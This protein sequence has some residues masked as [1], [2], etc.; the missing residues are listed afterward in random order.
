MQETY[1]LKYDSTIFSYTLY[2]SDGTTAVTAAEWDVLFGSAGTANFRFSTVSPSAAYYTIQRPTGATAPSK[3]LSSS[4]NTSA[5]VGTM[6]RGT[7]NASN[8]Q[9]T[10]FV[11]YHGNTLTREQLSFLMGKIK[12][13]ESR[14]A[15][16]EGN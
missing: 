10:S 9:F 12:A 4:I 14:V 6:Y 7:W 11:E 3:Y 8:Y 15:A 2:H 5:A 13:L 16:L 1:I